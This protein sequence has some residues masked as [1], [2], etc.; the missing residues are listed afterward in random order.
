MLPRGA[1]VAS[2]RNGFTKSPTSLAGCYS[3]LLAV[4]LGGNGQSG[5]VK[6]WEQNRPRKGSAAIWRVVP[7]GKITIKR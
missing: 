7:F 4:E 3:R 5:K 6:E 2:D 1:S